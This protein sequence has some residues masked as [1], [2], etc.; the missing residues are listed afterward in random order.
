MTHSE[1]TRL[2]QPDESGVLDRGLTAQADDGLHVATGYAAGEDMR[3]ENAVFG[4]IDT[5]ATGQAMALHTRERQGEPGANDAARDQGVDGAVNRDVIRA[6]HDQYWR[7][8]DNPQAS[9]AGDWAMHA[10]LA[11]GSSGHG[12]EGTDDRTGAPSTEGWSIEALLSGTRLLED[13]F[14]PLRKGEVPEAEVEPIPEILRL[15]APAEYLAAASRRPPALPAA[16]TRRE[17]QTPGIDSPL[18]AP[19]STTHHKDSP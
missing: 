13:V 4:L 1:P 10:S 14:G 18:P 3:G 8:L 5:A 17:H 16:L 9:L 12:D 19:D 7:A 15:F 11:S 6:L 2:W